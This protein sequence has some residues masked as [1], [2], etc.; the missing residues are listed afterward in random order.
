MLAIVGSYDSD[1]ADLR[2]DCGDSMDEQHTELPLPDSQ[3]LKSLVPGNECR[4]VYRYLY[5]RR[6]D[7]PTQAAIDNYVAVFYGESHSQT[8]RRRRDLSTEYGFDIRRVR[9]KGTSKPGYRLVGFRPDF[10]PAARIDLKTRA[11]VIHTY[12]ERCAMCGRNPTEH[13]VV[14][15]LDHKIPKDWGG[16]T[17]ETNLWPLCEY[18][19]L[20]KKNDFSSFSS[21]AGAISTAMQHEDVW[22]RC[23][24][25]LKALQGQEVPDYLLFLIVP[26]RNRGDY[27]KRVR[28]L[29]FVLG[30]EIELRKRKD[31][32]SGKYLSLYVCHSWQPWP[33]EGARAAV[34]TYERRRQRRKAKPDSQLELD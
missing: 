25:L 15:H 17:D 29:R 11:K 4:L 32:A 7:P 16:V 27:K 8:Q 34:T 5:Q 18:C 10:T 9:V 13:G 6:N 20:G 22:T 19:N 24:E 23:G 14:L 12:N 3:E 31:P 33:P 2:T 1:A 30:W 28:E 26:E 21:A